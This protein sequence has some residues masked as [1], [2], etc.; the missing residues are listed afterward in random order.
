MAKQR[1]R[2]KRK[3]ERR[4]EHAAS[5]RARDLDYH[6]SEGYGNALRPDYQE[7]GVRAPGAQRRDPTTR[8]WGWI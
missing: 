5:I 4:A 1:I 2:W 8:I 3:R 7:S 6:F